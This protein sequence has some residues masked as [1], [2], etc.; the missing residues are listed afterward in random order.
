MD[1]VNLFFVGTA[2]SGKSTLTGALQ[3]WMSLQSYDAVPINLDPGVDDLNY[4]PG[5]DIREWLVLSDIMEEYNLGPN[6]AQVACADMLAIKMPEVADL[7][8]EI[9]TDY[10]LF[11]TPGQVELFAFRG[12][13]ERIIDTMGSQRSALIYLLDP[14]LAKTPN[15]FISQI[16]LASIVQFRFQ[17]PLIVLLSKI[18]ILEQPELDMMKGWSSEQDA[19][20]NAILDGDSTMSTQFSVEMARI[21]EDIGVNYQ[22][23][24]VSAHTKEGLEDIYN[25]VQ[26]IF[27]G[28]EDIEAPPDIQH[29]TY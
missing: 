4:K 3:E 24:P 15:G 9:H 14:F 27:A 19:L 17:V 8:S 1:P 28:G 10:F 12:S 21:F 13:S 25:M 23:I 6:G 26:Q 20:Y 22:M 5:F 18:D 16:M 2:G 7:L 11:D 29:E